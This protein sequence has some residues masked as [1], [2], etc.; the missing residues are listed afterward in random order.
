MDAIITVDLL[1]G[2]AQRGVHQQ[3]VAAP[4]D[5]GGSREV[6]P[7]LLVHSDS[8]TLQGAEEGDYA[9]VGINAMQ[10]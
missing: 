2:T 3:L 4:W 6:T 9:H 7:A 8:F 5:I 1:G 10:G